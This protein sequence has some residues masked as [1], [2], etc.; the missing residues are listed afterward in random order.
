MR[1]DVAIVWNSTEPDVGSEGDLEWRACKR[2][3]L[4]HGAL[5]V[6]VEFGRRESRGDLDVDRLFVRLVM[7]H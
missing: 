1:E 7:T 6:V 5:D 4:G 2:E 3:K